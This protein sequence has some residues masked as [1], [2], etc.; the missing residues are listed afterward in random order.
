MGRIVKGA[1]FGKG[2]YLLTVPE[3]KAPPPILAIV[4]DFGESES[5]ESAIIPEPIAAID[6]EAVRAQ[7]EG[8]IDTASNDAQALL[9]DAQERALALMADG[10]SRS[11]RIEEEARTAGLEQGTQ[12]GRD[13]AN[14]EMEGMLTTMRGLVEMARVERHKIILSAEPEIVR[15][16]T[17]I[18]ERI[19]HKQIGLDPMVV[20]DMT[21]AAIARLL[22]R[23]TVT[24]R[25]NP[26][27]I[28]TVREH[29]DHIL[30]AGDI[31]HMRIIEDQRVDRG[32]VLVETQSGTIDAKVSTQFREAKRV[33]QVEDAIAMSPPSEPALFVRPAQVG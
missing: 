29:R 19:L 23:E 17:V 21:K 30:G 13:A 31:E 16:S 28:E 33:L 9:T 2:N 7:A 26:A 12:A 24:V 4:D 25:V 3:L 11:L 18:A 1:G 14:V 6:W 22:S 20:V 10:A 15:L 8:L 32:G 27:D 5:D